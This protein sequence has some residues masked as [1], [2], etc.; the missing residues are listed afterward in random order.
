MGGFCGDSG[1][2]SGKFQELY[3]RL[4]TLVLYYVLFHLKFY[5][6]PFF[7][8]KQNTSSVRLHSHDYDHLF[9]K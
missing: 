2:V 9:H 5:G 4:M 7:Q 1:G 6:F 8:H 3:N